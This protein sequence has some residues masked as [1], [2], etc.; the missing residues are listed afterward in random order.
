MNIRRLTSRN[1]LLGTAVLAVSGAML[2]FAF[3][4]VP[5][6]SLICTTLGIGGTT[7]RATAAPTEISDIPMTIRLDANTDKQLPWLFQP[8]EK[9]VALKLGETKTI[10]YRASNTSDH[11]ITGT[12][13]F[14]VTPEK[15][16]RYFNKL[17]CFCFQEQTLQPGQ[18]A[19]MGVTFFIDPALVKDSTTDEVRTITL[20][21]TF[22]KSLKG[23][24]ASD[25]SAAADDTK[26]RLAPHSG[27]ASI[28]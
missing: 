27:P 11:A 24:P 9:S 1:A 19:D 20:S 5:L 16:G 28:N 12:A 18:S 23:L 3:A 10:F 21:Y 17:D 13:T 6:F 7:Q 26:V 4:M 2:G 8:V 14:N 25:R 15:I 22:Y